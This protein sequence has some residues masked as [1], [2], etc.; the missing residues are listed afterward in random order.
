M[1]HL[2]VKWMGNFMAYMGG[3]FMAQMDGAVSYPFLGEMLKKK[4]WSS[5]E[6]PFRSSYDH[7]FRSL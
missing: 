4:Y 5:G 2:W 3:A 6:Y 7:R 1:G